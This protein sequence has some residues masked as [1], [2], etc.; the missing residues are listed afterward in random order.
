MFRLLR[1]EYYWIAHVCIFLVVWICTRCANA[2]AETLPELHPRQTEALV[3][4][5]RYHAEKG[6]PPSQRE[7]SRALGFSSHNPGVFVTPLLKKGLLRRTKAKHRNIV[8]TQLAGIWFKHW[9]ES[10]PQA[11]FEN[12]LFREVRHV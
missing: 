2:V 12:K 9:Q 5:L 6:V 1:P 8:P 10:Q 7:I 4:I 11:D 3:F